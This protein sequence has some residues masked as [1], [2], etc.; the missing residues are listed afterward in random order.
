MNFSVN[1]NRMNGELNL[2]HFDDVHQ[3]L[4]TFLS[5][6]SVLFYFFKDI[7][8]WKNSKLHV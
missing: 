3:R 6:I 4:V 1:I 7:C 2:L 5:A 8:L